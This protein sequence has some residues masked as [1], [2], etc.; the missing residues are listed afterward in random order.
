MRVGCYEAPFSSTHRLNLCPGDVSQAPAGLGRP[1]QGRLTRCSLA[2][3]LLCRKECGILLRIYFGIQT[4]QQKEM[5]NV[6]MVLREICH[7]RS[8]TRSL[9]LS[10]MSN[11]Q[12]Y[13]EIPKKPRRL[14][15]IDV[16]ADAGWRSPNGFPRSRHVP[17][18][19]RKAGHHCS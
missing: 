3:V 15:P 16:C 17:T 19:G 9:L 6:G 18:C 1:S 8:T 10:T 5:V 11:Q 12:I 2:Q 7:F 13:L 4:Y 14:T